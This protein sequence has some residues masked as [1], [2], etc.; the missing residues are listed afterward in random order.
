MLESDDLGGDGFDWDQQRIDRM[1]D[2][3]R[4]LFALFKRTLPE[5]RYD[6]WIG[7]YKKFFV[8]TVTVKEFADQT[9]DILQ[10]A[11]QAENGEV[12][13]ALWEIARTNLRWKRRQ[14]DYDSN[15][16]PIPLRSIVTF[17]DRRAL[18]AIRCAERGAS[19]ERELV[20]VL[21]EAGNDYIQELVLSSCP[22]ADGIDGFIETAGAKGPFGIP[23]LHHL[24]RKRSTDP[25]LPEEMRE[26][27]ARQLA[28]TIEKTTEAQRTARAPRWDVDADEE[29]DD[30]YADAFD[31]DE[32]EADVLGQPMKAYE[33]VDSDEEEG[34]QEM[35]DG[36]LAGVEQL[37]QR[38][39]DHD[40]TLD[41]L[42]ESESEEEDEP[43]EKEHNNK[44]PPTR[45]KND[46]ARAGEEELD[47]KKPPTSPEKDEEHEPPIK[48]LPA[49]VDYD[50]EEEEQL[51]EHDIPPSP[52]EKETL[53]GNEAKSGAEAEHPHFDGRGD[54]NE[55]MAGNRETDDWEDDLDMT[56]TM[57]QFDDALDEQHQEL[58][59]TLDEAKSN[60]SAST[61][62]R[63]DHDDDVVKTSKDNGDGEWLADWRKTVNLTGSAGDDQAEAAQPGGRGDGDALAAAF[64]DDI[65]FSDQ[66]GPSKRFNDLLQ[67]MPNDVVLPPNS[68]DEHDEDVPPPTPVPVPRPTA[69]KTRSQ[70]VAEK[71][72]PKKPVVD[73]DDDDKVS[74]AKRKRTSSHYDDD[75]PYNPRRGPAKSKKP[76]K[77]K[78]PTAA[79]RSKSKGRRVD[80]QLD[81]GNESD[82]DN[83]PENDDFS[84]PDK[85]GPS[86]PKRKSPPKRE[87]KMANN[88]KEDKG[89]GE[90]DE[91]DTKSNNKKKPASS[92]K[93]PKE[94]EEEGWSSDDGSSTIDPDHIPTPKHASAAKKHEFKLA[95]KQLLKEKHNLPTLARL[96]NELRN[97][98]WQEEED[99]EEEQEEDE[100]EEEEAI[101]S[102]STDATQT[103]TAI[104]EMQRTAAPNQDT[105]DIPLAT[106]SAQINSIH[107]VL[108]IPHLM[109]QIVSNVVDLKS[110]AALDHVSRQFHHLSRKTPFAFP[111]YPETLRLTFRHWFSAAL[112][113]GIGTIEV[114]SRVDALTQNS[115]GDHPVGQQPPEI[116][117]LI[118]RIVSRVGPQHIHRLQIGVISRRDSARG[119]LTRAIWYSLLLALDF[120]IA[121]FPGRFPLLCTAGLLQY[122]DERLPAV[123]AIDFANCVFD[124]GASQ[125]LLSPA[126]KFPH[127]L[128][129]LSFNRCS[130]DQ[131]TPNIVELAMRKLITRRL[132]T[133][134]INMFSLTSQGE[135]F[136]VALETLYHRL[137]T[138]DVFIDEQ[139][140]STDVTAADGWVFLKRCAERA[141]DLRLHFRKGDPRHSPKLFA[142]ARD[143]F[144]FSKL[145]ELDIGL[146]V[147]SQEELDNLEALVK[148]LYWMR[149]KSFDFGGFSYR[150]A[151]PKCKTILKALAVNLHQQNTLEKFSISS[152][153]REY[154]Q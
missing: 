129:D 135:G 108:N 13:A 10:G 104:A 37:S 96:R 70:S 119:V 32:F 115:R 95:M 137:D 36:T 124:H 62:D 91:V 142:V 87:K 20:D 80:D 146:P 112:T 88:I 130:F 117:T 31:L 59:N 136:L 138:L 14:R 38:V 148:G 45:P 30:L 16:Q 49:L 22:Q 149:L 82:I 17:G 150:L 133:F 93:K 50:E 34:E 24:L 44:E 84:D 92:K 73:A 127:R 103:L 105:S 25:E 111:L 116:M 102:R 56:A 140:F 53:R 65:S 141:K 100:H 66:P 152:I 2:R 90:E 78:K 72:P 46:G 121:F 9:G 58:N 15:G 8:G 1:M 28:T 123:T 75:P 71:A 12:R 54:H 131:T 120:C 43:E 4:Q 89:R 23:D 76:A 57:G 126:C 143:C 81:D 5:P 97:R 6:L 21:V 77:P 79:S 48:T 83:L 139:A 99:E 33:E 113:V 110:R 19:F 134:S 114:T 85:P 47:K 153:A 151:G 132:R 63:G 61:T 128:A 122:I 86:K 3:L 68:D 35:E 40:L 42:E 11:L 18:L 118:D 41:L 7:L 98:V 55:E 145:S 64:G 74:P 101:E 52:V 26:L 27:A 51:L 109:E 106:T 144:Q 125:Y 94:A 107:R 60:A 147:Q 29:D 67:S 154:E 39:D 69:T